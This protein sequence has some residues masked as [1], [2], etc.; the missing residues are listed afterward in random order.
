MRRWRA[1]RSYLPSTTLMILFPRYVPWPLYSA[2]MNLWQDWLRNFILNSPRWS[3][4]SLYA[5]SSLHW[6]THHEKHSCSNA[7]D[8][9][10]CLV[11]A[12]DSN[13]QTANIALNGEGFFGTFVM[14]PV[15]D[16]EFIV[17]RPMQTISRGKLNGVCFPE[18]RMA[19]VVNGSLS[20]VL[21]GCTAGA[22]I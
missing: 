12:D 15:V 1:Q 10:A 3:G 8:T 20:V 9:F 4:E 6:Y 13:L 5:E 7:T 17:E 16:G 18:H 22:K 14:V 11:D 21:P 2:L 19:S